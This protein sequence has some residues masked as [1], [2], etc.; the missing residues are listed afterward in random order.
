[1]SVRQYNRP[2]LGE[3]PMSMAFSNIKTPSSVLSNFIAENFGPAASIKNQKALL[4]NRYK[5]EART[6]ALSDDRWSLVA[7]Y[8][9]VSIGDNNFVNVYVN[10][11]SALVDEANLIEFGDTQNPPSAML[12]KLQAKFTDDVKM[13]LRGY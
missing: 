11:P 7:D 10:A 13:S 5:F 3:K 4:T 1:M 9:D 8:I 2:E 12:R 6:A